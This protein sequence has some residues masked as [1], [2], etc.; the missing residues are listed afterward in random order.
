MK[1]DKM[2]CIINNELLRMHKD[3]QDDISLD[4]IVEDM[5]G[6]YPGYVKFSEY[7]MRNNDLLKPVVNNL[8]VSELESIAQ[9][10]ASRLID[11]NLKIV[12]NRIPESFRYNEVEKGLFDHFISELIDYYNPSNRHSNIESR[13]NTCINLV[14]TLNDYVDKVY[15]NDLICKDLMYYFIDSV[16]NIVLKGVKEFADSLMGTT[17][18]QRL[19]DEGFILY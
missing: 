10:L 3:E 1:K 5:T 14:T 11:D 13:L 9:Y 6:L 18:Y 2:N 16:S 7:L 12:N 19:M 8:K 4:S 17:I 15:D